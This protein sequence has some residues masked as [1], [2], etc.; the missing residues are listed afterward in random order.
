MPG[1]HV[2]GGHHSHHSHHSHSHHSHSSHHHYHHHHHHSYNGY[3]G[4]SGGKSGCIA[5]MVIMFLIIPAI[6]MVYQALVYD[7]IDDTYDT[8]RT[9]SASYTVG[10][11]EKIDTLPSVCNTEYV[12]DN[13]NII[14]DER[15]VI[16]ALRYFEQ[17]TGI[18]PVLITEATLPNNSQYASDYEIEQYV[19]EQYEQRFDDEQHMI[20]YYFSDIDT[21]GVIW[22]ETGDEAD[23]YMD[24][25]AWDILFD[26]VETYLVQG[27][28]QKAFTTG[29]TNAA[30]KLSGN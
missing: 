5:V 17:K 28:P 2:G 16:R 21:Q 4:S 20:F 24:S 6:M 8:Y 27:D 11:Y 18:C 14:T 9:D 1:R 13:I 23:E 12:E 26:E 30:D 22:A 29:F 3:G 19:I 15:Q 25:A 10:Y 7:V